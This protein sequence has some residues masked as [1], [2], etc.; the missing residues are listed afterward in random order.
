MPEY[1]PSQE[2]AHPRQMELNTRVGDG[3]EHH[4]EQTRLQV[5]EARAQA[6]YY[7]QRH[8]EWVEQRRDLEKITLQKTFFSENLNEVGTKIS[9]CLKRIE[10]E[11]DSLERE[12]QSLEQ[13]QG[14]LHGHLKIL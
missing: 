11:I 13:I 6:A 9:N 8:A 12:E 2:R 4:A 5:E 3:E 7:E 10:M 14:C 1:Q